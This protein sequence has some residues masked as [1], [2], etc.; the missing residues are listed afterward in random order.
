MSTSDLEQ[1]LRDLSAGNSPAAPLAC[2]S[3]WAFHHVDACPAPLAAAVAEIAS[4]PPPGLILY[5]FGSRSIV[6]TYT[7][8]SGDRVVLK[9]YYPNSLAK[10]IT[11][12]VRGSRCL[13]SWR[14]GAA[15]HFIGVPTP[16]PLAIAEWQHLGGLW[17]SKSFLA[18]RQADG[19]ALDAFI[20][21]HGMDHPLVPKAVESL[22]RSFALMAAHRAVHG[23][24]KASNLLLSDTGEVSFIDLDAACFLLPSARWKS[25]REKD[26]QRFHANWKNL[27][28]AAA[29]FRNVFD[30]P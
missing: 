24:L 30:S 18:T 6:G 21:S 10:H 2:G 28:D 23:D 13:Q 15:F 9:Y 7:L 12:G 5:K 22:R 25:L 19:I 17:L 26:R 29:L 20:R 14:A 1:L 4:R 16:A 3:A 8:G 27:P 11:Y